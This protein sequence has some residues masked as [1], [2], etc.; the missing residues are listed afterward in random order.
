MTKANEDCKDFSAKLT[1]N[2][3]VLADEKSIIAPVLM[4]LR[5]A[6]EKHSRQRRKDSDGSPYVNHLIDIAQILACVAWGVRT[7]LRRRPPF[8]ATVSRIHKHRSRN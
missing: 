6:A 4:A 2:N 5:F 3:V 7:S 8:F 1:R